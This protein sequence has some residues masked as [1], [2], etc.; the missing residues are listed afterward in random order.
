MKERKKERWYEHKH[1][2]ASAS[3]VPSFTAR[4]EPPGLPYTLPL[5]ET[6]AFYVTVPHSPAGGYA[7]HNITALFYRTLFEFERQ[8]LV[9][10][11]RYYRVRYVAQAQ[12][13]AHLKDSS[14]STLSS[15]LFCP[16]EKQ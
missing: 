8:D 12:N 5:R 4:S 10:P 11:K 13:V 3:C 16:K 2:Q 14:R 15:K 6:I 9:L 7:L 1:N